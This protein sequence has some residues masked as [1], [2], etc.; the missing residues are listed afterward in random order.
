MKL[1]KRKLTRVQLF[2]DGDQL[3]Q[4][5]QLSELTGMHKSEIIR[6]ILDDKKS[7]LAAAITKAR[8]DNN[9]GDLYEPPTEPKPAPKKQKPKKPSAKKPITNDSFAKLIREQ[10]KR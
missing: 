4:L 8:A 10:N 9:Q 3:A 2:L 7:E 1:K 6:A 5:A